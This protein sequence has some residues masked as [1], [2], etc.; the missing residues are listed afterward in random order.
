MY[1]SRAVLNN[2][3]GSFRFLLY[4]CNCNHY[5]ANQEINH[6]NDE[7]GNILENYVNTNA[8]DDLAPRTARP[9][10]TMK[11]NKEIR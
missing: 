7:T 3:T 10:P 1:H 4:M 9:S 6:Y 2:S 11:L 5:F 8:A